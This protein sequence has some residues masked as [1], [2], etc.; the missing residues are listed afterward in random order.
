MFQKSTSK[1]F[2]KKARKIHGEVYDYSKVIYKRSDQKVTIICKQHGPFRQVP[3]SHLDGAG[4]RECG[5]SNR[6]YPTKLSLKEIEARMFKVHGT[7]YDLSRAVY[8]NCMEEFEVIC[9][10]HGSFW[11]QP[12]SFIHAGQGCRQCGLAERGANQTEK[13]R[14]SF[15]SRARE[16][17]G[18]RYEYDMGSLVNSKTPMRMICKIHGEFFRTPC[19]HLA[20]Q[21]C[22]ICGRERTT[23][24][25]N[26]RIAVRSGRRDHLIADP[27]GGTGLV[28]HDERL[29]CVL[30][31]H[32]RD[33]YM[34]W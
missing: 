28:L 21:G 18:E 17:H 30:R 16:I 13:F 24:Y 10:T 34:K 25:S 14:K 31:H 22:I 2:I 32:V 27:S 5:Y 7:K 1:E 19:D 8:V 6:T 12:V 20:N 11:I 26:K 29:A 23:Q 3:N 9:P 4:C 15:V 33:P